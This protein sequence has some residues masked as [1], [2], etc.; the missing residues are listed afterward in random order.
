[1][2]L[3]IKK[4][5]SGGRRCP[6]LH[7]QVVNGHLQ[8]TFEGSMVTKVGFPGPYGHLNFETAGVWCNATQPRILARTRGV[9]HTS[10]TL[11]VP[12][13]E[14]LRVAQPTS[15]QSN[16]LVEIPDITGPRART[17]I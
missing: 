10:F 17:L 9:Y 12:R 1:M 11:D 15:V 4:G 6:K 14:L 16:L 2:A 3:V 8:A 5:F 7:A 13:P